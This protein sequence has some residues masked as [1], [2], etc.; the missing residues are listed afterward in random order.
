MKTSFLVLLSVF[1]IGCS[2]SATTESSID[3]PSCDGADG[4]ELFDSDVL[5]PTSSGSRVKVMHTIESKFVCIAE[6]S[7]TITR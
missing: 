4:A 7:A 2:D 5:T 3:V 6:G 1:I